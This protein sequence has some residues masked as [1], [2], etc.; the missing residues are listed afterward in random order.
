MTHPPA[1]GRPKA[2]L[3]LTAPPRSRAVALA[4]WTPTGFPG[5][6]LS[7]F[8]LSTTKTWV[9]KPPLMSFRAGS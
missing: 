6:A 5:P 8:D 7:A 4:S 2:L 1:G 3:R 9:N